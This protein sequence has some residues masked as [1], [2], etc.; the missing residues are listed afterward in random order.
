MSVDQ[1][2]MFMRTGEQ[3]VDQ[4]GLESIT[5]QAASMDGMTTAM[6]EI[7]NTTAAANRSAEDFTKN[8]QMQLAYAP[9][10]RQ[11]V[12]K[13]QKSYEKMA[14]DVMKID[15]PPSAIANFQASSA[16]FRELGTQ[17]LGELVE[18]GTTAAQS[19]LDMLSD[20]MSE[21]LGVSNELATSNS[22]I[23]AEFDITSEGA[24]K[25]GKAIVDNS[26]NQEFVDEIKKIDSLSQTERDAFIR[27][28]EAQNGEIK[29]L[30]ASV[31][32]Q[33]IKVE[34]NLD[35]GKVIDAI[36]KRDGQSSGI[37]KLS[38]VNVGDEVLVSQKE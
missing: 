12:A 4:A 37:K 35:G 15:L 38:L 34:L 11:E 27:Q 10:I 26:G 25:V 20:G 28:I 16:K 3:A 7:G 13:T 17:N 31:Q 6:K 21:L 23:A 8:M 14:Q 19:A 36:I 24:S 29:S 30:T 5:D 33:E 1:M 18:M 2:K 22:V 9:G 32:N